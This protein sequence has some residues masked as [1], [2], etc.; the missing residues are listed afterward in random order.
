MPSEKCVRTAKPC[1][2]L[3]W[4]HSAASGKAVKGGEA[5][6]RQDWVLAGKSSE[7]RM[8]KSQWHFQKIAYMDVAEHEAWVG[9]EAKPPGKGW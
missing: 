1:S 6:S 8:Q 7:G 3:L 9:R 2:V 4:P 5:E